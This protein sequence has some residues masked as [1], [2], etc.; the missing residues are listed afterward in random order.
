MRILLIISSGKE[1]PMT[2]ELNIKDIVMRIWGMAATGEDMHNLESYIT[3]LEGENKKLQAEI[4]SIVMSHEENETN[5]NEKIAKLEEENKRLRE[6][7]DLE[8]MLTKNAESWKK[9][10]EQ[11][12]DDALQ[13]DTHEK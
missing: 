2:D 5:Y 8:H 7:G 13:K 11:T 3:Q 12:S 4:A 9:V 10:M 1:Q 6:E